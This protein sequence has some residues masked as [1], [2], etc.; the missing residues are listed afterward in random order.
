MRCLLP[1]QREVQKRNIDYRNVLG[2]RPCKSDYET[3]FLFQNAM[4]GHI[5]QLM[6]LT[7]RENGKMIA[8]VRLHIRKHHLITKWRLV[9]GSRKQWQGNAKTIEQ[10]RI[11]NQVVPRK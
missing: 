6:L 8:Q 10:W 9:L 7:Q 5:F 1:A 2:S 4:Y 11:L 3:V